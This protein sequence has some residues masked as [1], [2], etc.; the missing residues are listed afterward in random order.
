MSDYRET[1]S[2]KE[3]KRRQAA[4]RADS[5]EKRRQASLRRLARGAAAL[6]VLA[7]VVVAG[8]AGLGP[9]RLS[10]LVDFTQTLGRRGKGFP[11]ESGGNVLQAALVGGSLA[12][13]R[14][15]KLEVYTS[16]AYQS[17]SARQTYA[18]PALRAGSGRLAQFD[19][20]AGKVSLLS[21]TGLLFEAE[22]PGALFCVGLGRRGDLA[23]ACGAEGAASE[24]TAWDTKGAQVFNW[25]CEKEYP[26]A[27]QPNK[28]G[29]GLGLCLIGMEQAGAYARFVEFAYDKAQPLTDLR[30][31]DAWLYGASQRNGCWLAVGDQA[32]YLMKR[33]AQA[34]EALSYEGRAL[35]AFALDEAGYCAVLLEDWDNRALLRVYNSRGELAAEQG[36]ARRPLE[37]SCRGGSV[38]LR[39]DNFLLRWQKTTGLRQCDAIPPGAQS[40]FP[41]GGAAYIITVRSVE[42][43]R[44]RWGAADKGLF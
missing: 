15:T 6:A 19:R 24:I 36:F 32:V 38:Y 16:T 3:D 43:V 11:L 10:G 8:W 42:R 18:D 22:L 2:L 31:Q 14:P 27:L 33:G 34:P 17:L 23:A 29:S 1:R 37:L 13:L 9:V 30:V 4:A 40:V 28:N 41:T 25:R 21:K 39:F 26:S 7:A 12:M 5:R 44:L 20:A 35:Q